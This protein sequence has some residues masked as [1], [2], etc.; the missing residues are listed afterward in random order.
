MVDVAST[1]GHPKMPRNKLKNPTYTFVRSVI[2]Y[3][4]IPLTVDMDREPNGIQIMLT[5][6]ALW[7]L[8]QKDKAGDAFCTCELGSHPD[9]VYSRR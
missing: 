6:S 5:T 1:G 7:N 3:F 4:S 2:T 8:K 9:S